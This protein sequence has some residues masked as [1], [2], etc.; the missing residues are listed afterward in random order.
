MRRLSAFLTIAA[1]VAVLVPSAALAA[2]PPPPSIVSATVSGST[3]YTAPDCTLNFF[4]DFTGSVYEVRF[5]PVVAGVDG[6]P[7]TIRVP[8][9]YSAVATIEY[10]ADLATLEYSWKVALQDRKGKVLG[11]EI[12]TTAEKWDDG[13]VCPESGLLAAYPLWLI[14]N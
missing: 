11:Y 10:V 5:T 12:P 14:P 3:G 4:A 8:K 6:V 1:L 2:K 9:K 7:F 13:A